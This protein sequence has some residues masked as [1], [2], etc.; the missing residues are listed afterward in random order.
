MTK[1]RKAKSLSEGLTKSSEPTTP[2]KPHW[3][4]TNNVGQAFANALNEAVMKQAEE[5]ER[6]KNAAPPIITGSN[7]K[8]AG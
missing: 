1:T 4:V 3:G 7:R 2:V 8:S 6:V 5:K